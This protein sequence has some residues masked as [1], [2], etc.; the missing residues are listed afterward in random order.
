[1]QVGELAFLAFDG[2]DGLGVGG[3]GDFLLVFALLG[4]I[5]D[6]VRAINLDDRA[7]QGLLLGGLG[8]VGGVNRGGNHH[9]DR[10]N[11]KQLRPR[12]HVRCSSA[13]GLTVAADENP[14]RPG[15]LRD[16]RDG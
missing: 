14:C 3:D 8:F 4:G 2:D 16:S 5:N 13:P 7:F 9:D 11:R 6:Q 15:P 12:L 10:Q 1:M